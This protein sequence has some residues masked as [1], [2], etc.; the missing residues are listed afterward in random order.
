[1]EP[2]RPIKFEFDTV[3]GSKGALPTA[4]AARARSSYSSEEVETIRRETFQL[5]KA[6]T[7]AQA[8]AAHA[9]TLSAI[10]QSLIRMI[11]EF[12][13]A[14]RTMREDSAVIALEVARKLAQV[15]L[16]A[17]PL[18]EVE[19]LLA[20]CLHKLHREPRI[21]VRV[22]SACA[23][24]LREDIDRLCAEHAFSGR[25]VIIAE[26]SIIGSDCRIEWADGGVE[27]DLAVTLAAI[28]QSAERW[29]SSNPSEEN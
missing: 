27:R 18:K 6:D 9:A 12:D 21:V 15:A 28:E 10:A 7:E 1:M 11:G 17:Y 24:R 4:A 5:G 23:E 14:V 26:P 19:A 25:V 8:A 29:R 3:F 2:A 16:E 22:S 13:A 20:D